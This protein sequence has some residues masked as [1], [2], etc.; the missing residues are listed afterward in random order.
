[1]NAI[2]GRSVRFP[3][4]TVK[5]KVTVYLGDCKLDI[6]HTWILRVKGF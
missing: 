5:T 6:S 3:A 2:K 4:S 1:M